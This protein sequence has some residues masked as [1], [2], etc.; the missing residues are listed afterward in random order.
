MMPIAINNNKI[1][2]NEIVFKS[3]LNSCNLQ[4]ENKR[5]L[6]FAFVLY[7]FTNPELMR[8]LNNPSYWYSLNVISGKTI[9]ISYLNSSDFNSSPI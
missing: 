7:D 2:S 5:A 3:I 6:I 9:S 4:R 1:L 8:L